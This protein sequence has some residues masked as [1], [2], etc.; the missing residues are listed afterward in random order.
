MHSDLGRFL[1]V[2]LGPALPKSFASAAALDSFGDPS[3]L[4]AVD[5]FV[6]D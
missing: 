3:F 4:H 5:A 6:S 1:D 2:V